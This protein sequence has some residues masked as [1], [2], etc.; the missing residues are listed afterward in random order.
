MDAKVAKGSRR[1]AR[2]EALNGIIDEL[3]KWFDAKI[4]GWNTVEQAI[5][6]LERFRDKEL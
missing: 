2:K 6:R 3:Q 4:M 1:D 5:R